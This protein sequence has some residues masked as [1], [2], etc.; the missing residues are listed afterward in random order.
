MNTTFINSKNTKTSKSHVLIRNFTDKIDLRRDKK[1]IALS[2]LSIYYTWKDIK[3][4]YNYNKFK[5]SGPLRMINLNY[6]I[7]HILYLIFKIIFKN[8]ENR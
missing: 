6:Q 2:N 8:M 5:I 3:S 1:S 4:S 7:D